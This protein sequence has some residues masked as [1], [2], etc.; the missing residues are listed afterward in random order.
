MNMR[1]PDAKQDVRPSQRIYRVCNIFHEHSVSGFVQK[2]LRT[3]IIFPGLQN[4]PSLSSLHKF[5]LQGG[6]STSENIIIVEYHCEIL[7]FELKKLG[8]L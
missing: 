8:I 3:C 2:A 6:G 5:V 7:N 4:N 1:S